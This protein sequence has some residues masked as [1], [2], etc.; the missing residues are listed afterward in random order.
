MASLCE[1]STF[2]LLTP[3]HAGGLMGLED[4]PMKMEDAKVRMAVQTKDG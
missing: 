4:K 2:V 1:A 3:S